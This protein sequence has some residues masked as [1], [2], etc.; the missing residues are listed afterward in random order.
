MNAKPTFTEKQF[1]G[2]NTYGL[3]RRLVMIVFCFIAHYYSEEKPEPTGLFFLV[4]C[5]TIVISLVL[6]FIPLYTITLENG[7]LQLKTMRNKVI[8]IPLPQILEV[9]AVKYSRYHFN[10]PVFNVLDHTEYKC[11]AEG[12]KAHLIKLESGKVYRIG[13]KDADRLFSE[14]MK[15]KAKNQ[16][17]RH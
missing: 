7:V 11:Y 16:S 8:Q 9:E 6:L 10:N 3:S 4:G 5:V 1:L 15:M 13:V 12:A 2:R 14:I 17:S